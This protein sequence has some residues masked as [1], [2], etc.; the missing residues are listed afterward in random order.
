MTPAPDGTRTQAERTE[1]TRRALITAGRT[2]FAAKGFAAVA[3]TELATAAG[4]SR[5]AMYHQFAD[6]SALF[7]AVVEQIELE[8]MDRIAAGAGTS[9]DVGR[10]LLQAADVWFDA[11]LEP[12]IQQIVLLDGPV[13][14]GWEAFRAVTLRYGAG[15]T[16]ALLRAGMDDGSIVDLPVEVLSAMLLGAL[17]EGAMLVARSV[18]PDRTRGEARRV[19]E[20]LIA[21]ICA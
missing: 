10:M 5:G 20:H 6:K 1:S 19:I 3:T 2:L 13:V 12:E 9:S 11:C 21:A 7:A 8:V 17:N 14:L 15:L 4:V 16:E 18:E